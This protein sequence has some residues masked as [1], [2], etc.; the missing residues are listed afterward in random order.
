MTSQ[1]KHILDSIKTIASQG[2]NPGM[3]ALLDVCGFSARRIRQ[4]VRN[5]IAQGYVH[6]VNGSTSRIKYYRLTN[7]AKAIAH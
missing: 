6:R 7:E 2:R 1:D 5:L 3:H 4:S